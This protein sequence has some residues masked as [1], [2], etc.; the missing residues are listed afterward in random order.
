MANLEKRELAVNPHRFAPAAP[1]EEYVY[2][3][4]CPG[5]HSAG[6]HAD[7]LEDW[8][9]FMSA[10]D[11]ERVCCVLPGSSHGGIGRNIDAYRDAFGRAN[12]RHVPITDRGLAD[13]RRLGDEIFPFFEQ[14]VGAGERVVV[15]GLDGIGRTGQ[16]LATWLVHDRQYSPQR[17]MSTV[18]RMGRLPD[19]PVRRGTISEDRFAEY[20]ASFR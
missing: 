12:V 10:N 11:I 5:W 14:A 13:K 7:A 9:S 2:G 20:L 6:S 17:A 15:H 3:A 18:E 19:D 16:V 8:L 4:C 1:D